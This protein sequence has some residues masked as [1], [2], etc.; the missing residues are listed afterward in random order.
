MHTPLISGKPA[1][2]LLDRMIKEF[3][4]LEKDA[5]HVWLDRDV[6]EGAYGMDYKPHFESFCESGILPPQVV[7]YCHERLWRS[8]L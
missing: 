5:C 7:D 3:R 1:R 6:F 4:G 2:D 8:K